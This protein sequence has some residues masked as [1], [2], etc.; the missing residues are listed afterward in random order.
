MKI[1]FSE[2]FRA[3]FSEDLDKELAHRLFIF[4]ALSVCLSTLTISVA[5]S[6]FD[7]NRIALIQVATSALSALSILIYYKTKSLNFAVQLLL[8]WILFS[9]IYRNF[10]MGGFDSPTMYTTFLIPLYTGFLLSY[11]SSMIWTFLFIMT[12][13]FFYIAPQLGFQISTEYSKESINS[14]KIFIIVISNI[15]CLNVIFSMKHFFSKAKHMLTKEKDEKSHLLKIITHDMASP[16]TN[17]NYLLQQLK[18]KENAETYEKA[19][20]ALNSIS[21]MIK[22]IKSYEAIKSGKQVLV[23]HAISWGQIFEEL[24]FLN[25]DSLSK[26]NIKLSVPSEMFVEMLYTDQNILVY[27]ILNNLI[28]NAIKFS[29]KNSEI[30][31]TLKNSDDFYEL[32]I[33]DSGIG[34]PDSMIKEIFNSNF[35]T[36]R[37]GTLGEKGTGFGL[38]IVKSFADLLN[39]KITITSKCEQDGEND[40]GTIVTLLIPIQ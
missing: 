37:Q 9:T 29:H 23:K 24:L 13:F 17:L 1:S 15:V 40:H 36:S 26:K 6:I 33:I 25:S 18:T 30:K 19:T 28:N 32:Q 16:L 14:V 5:Y 11:R 22:D 35:K 12:S 4:T 31:V 8:I 20:R 27:Q 10:K 2:I 3:H 39:V 34:I 7:I 38:P 21:R